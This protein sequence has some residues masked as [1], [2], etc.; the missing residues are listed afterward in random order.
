VPPK[1]KGKRKRETVKPISGLDVDALLGATKRTKISAENAIPEFKQAVH[2]AADVP[3]IGKAARQMY[4]IVCTIIRESFADINYDRAAENLRVMRE[5]LLDLEEP[6]LYNGL[7][8]EL[9]KKIVGGELD[10]DRMDMWTGKIVAGR[11]G[12]ITD[13]E[14]NGTDVTE[15]DAKKVSLLL[16]SGLGNEANMGNSLSSK[17]LQL[18]ILAG[19]WRF[20]HGLS[21]SELTGHQKEG[22]IAVYH[23]Y[24]LC[25]LGA[26]KGHLMCGGKITFALFGCGLLPFTHRIS[27]PSVKQMHLY[28]CSLSSLS[29]QTSTHC[30]TSKEPSREARCILR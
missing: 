24:S 4:E 16:T 10:G 5:E 30:V 1:V 15:A 18:L 14:I 8:R 11:L 22:L 19:I 27:S 2:T 13:Q 9:K 26:R 3:A 23:L 29:P 7:L 25:L 6:E 12:L 21:I 17:R 20:F 28:Y